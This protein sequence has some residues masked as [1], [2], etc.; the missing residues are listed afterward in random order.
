MCLLLQLFDFFIIASNLILLFFSFEL[1]IIDLKSIVFS[2]NETLTQYQ[3]SIQL[4]FSELGLSLWCSRNSWN[5]SYVIFPVFHASITD[6]PEVMAPILIAEGRKILLQKRGIMVFP[7]FKQIT[8]L[9][10]RLII[11]HSTKLKYL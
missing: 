4:P 3:S 2:K 11:D 1:I 9:Q 10:E 6:C 5:I 8:Y 7:S